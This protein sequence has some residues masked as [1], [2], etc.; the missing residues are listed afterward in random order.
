MLTRA[1]ERAADRAIEVGFDLVERTIKNPGAYPDFMVVLPFDPEFLSRIFTKE[2]L[3][4]WAEL[5]RTRPRS[6]TTLA[7]QVHRNVSRVRQDVLI[8]ERANLARTEKRGNEVRAWAQ[9][10]HIVIA[11]PNPLSAHGR[12]SVK[13]GKPVTRRHPAST[14]RR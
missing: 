10:P 3:R 5:Y 1:Q 4:L 7:K 6:L 2:R 11:T 13:S 12:N 14:S 9:A 8:L